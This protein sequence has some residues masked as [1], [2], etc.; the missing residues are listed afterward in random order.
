MERDLKCI[1]LVSAV[2][3]LAGC[4]AAQSSGSTGG[5]GGGA[6]AGG[7]GGS[8]GIGGQGGVGGAPG[9]PALK[10][11][12]TMPHYAVVSSDFSSSSIAML[13][14]SF[15]VIDESWL[16]SGTTYPGLVAT[17]S[18]NGALP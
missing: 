3:A 14:E 6:G 5:S 9:T 1:L 15:G 4:D 2:L 18:G 10:S 16:S 12:D 13:D 7:T 8:G 11:L 17:L